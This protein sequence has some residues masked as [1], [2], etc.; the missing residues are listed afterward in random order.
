M[1]SCC[2]IYTVHQKSVPLWNIR[3]TYVPHVFILYMQTLSTGVIS[4]PILL[5]RDSL[6]FIFM[7]TTNTII[8]YLPSF[9]NKEVSNGKRTFKYSICLT[10]KT[11]PPCDCSLGIVIAFGTSDMGWLGESLFFFNLTKSLTSRSG[12]HSDKYNCVF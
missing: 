9:G 11:C 7:N 8:F 1:W 2:F 5:L 10:D 12:S 3:E 4:M 6:I